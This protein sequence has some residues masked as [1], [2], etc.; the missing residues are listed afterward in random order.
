M[1][2]FKP[3]IVTY[4]KVKK[5]WLIAIGIALFLLAFSNTFILY[6][7]DIDKGFELFF[8]KRYIVFFFL[9]FIYLSWCSINI[10]DF[11]FLQVRFKSSN[12]LTAINLIIYFLVSLYMVTIELLI[13][14]MITLQNETI[15][16]DILFFSLNTFCFTFF[17]FIL[18]DFFYKVLH[19][20]IFSFF[21]ILSYLFFEDNLIL[22]F[23]W[24]PFFKDEWIFIERPHIQ[25]I[26]SLPNIFL[27][28]GVFAVLI[29]LYS[30]QNYIGKVF[31]KK[32]DR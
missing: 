13:S 14:S 7:K 22:K 19:N 27:F 9:P 26:Y 23:N 4:F 24:P 20:S 10:N 25:Q 15:N 6:E 17:L 3:F 11:P 28:I 21:L 1:N 12:Y 30:Y 29:I 16:I 32:G 8:S 5:K 2:S 18:L 31:R